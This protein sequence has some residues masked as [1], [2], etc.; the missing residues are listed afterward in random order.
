MY[1]FWIL[2]KNV[3]IQSFNEQM[4]RIGMLRNET[5]RKSNQLFQLGNGF[6]S[7]LLYAQRHNQRHDFEKSKSDEATSLRT[8]FRCT[9]ILKWF[10]Y[11]IQNLFY[12]QNRKLSFIYW[13]SVCQRQFSE[14][15]NFD[16]RIV[17][18]NYFI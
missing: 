2:N 4:L 11:R 15:M 16:C 9:W 5:H 18:R 12:R 7:T 1:G 10:A 6:V 13:Y 3:E 14:L 17:L 8:L